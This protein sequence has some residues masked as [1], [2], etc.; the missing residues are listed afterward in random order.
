[1]MIFHIFLSGAFFIGPLIT[2]WITQGGGW[3]WTVGFMAIAMFTNLMAIV[4]LFRESAYQRD[5][6]NKGPFEKRTYRQW[7]GLS[8]GYRRDVNPFRVFYEIIRLVMYPPV[9][10]AGFLIG[11]ISGANVIQDVISGG[12]L[13]K[14]PYK[15]GAGK[16]GSFQVGGFIGAL[17]GFF[18]GGRGIDYIAA[19]A[20]RRNHGVR[21]PEMRLPALLIPGFFGPAGIIV[22]GVT[23]HFLTPWIAPAIGVGMMGV[24]ITCVNNIGVTYAVDSYLPISGEV[25]TVVFVIR[26]TISCLVAL[27]SNTWAANMGVA[28]AF[29]CMAG[30]I[31]FV[32]LFGVLLY[33]WGKRVRLFTSTY[34]P[35]K[36]LRRQ[37]HQAHDTKERA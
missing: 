33:Y 26:N 32:F 5:L 6:L 15:F 23:F 16:V 34:G 4:F 24:A 14:E 28:Q 11:I 36:E 35:L 9:I 31:V 8:I 37:R 17:L 18:L 13:V 7:F 19:V 29:G 3:R 22:I 12:A 10:W 20:T 25:I 30:I 2:G 21:E 27:Y 1:M